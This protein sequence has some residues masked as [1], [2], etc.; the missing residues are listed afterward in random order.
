MNNSV[1]YTHYLG[2]Y[3][4]NRVIFLFYVYSTENLHTLQFLIVC[5]LAS[6]EILV[7]THLIEI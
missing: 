3:G 6:L 5:K 4:L 1:W 2:D 7:I